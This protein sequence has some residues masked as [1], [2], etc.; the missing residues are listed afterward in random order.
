LSR[1]LARPSA[2]LNRAIAATQCEGPEAGL[3][4]VD[5]LALDEYQYFHSTRGGLLRRLQRTEEARAG[6]A[7]ALELPGSEPE[8]RLLRCRLAEL[9]QLGR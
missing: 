2:E 4:I 6:F 1:S 3:A 7:C 9:S 8:R 5:A